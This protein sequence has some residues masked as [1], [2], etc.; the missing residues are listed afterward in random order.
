MRKIMVILGAYYPN[1]SANGICVG[2]I[3]DQLLQDGYSVFC[4]CNSQLGAP[5]KEDI[6][7]LHIRRIKAKAHKKYNE[8]VRRSSNKIQKS[9]YSLLRSLSDIFH[10]VKMTK[11]FPVAS[12]HHAKKIF[13]VANSILIEN[14]IDT[15]I[16][17]NMP[18]DTMYAAYLLK[19]EHPDID[20]IPYS[21]DPIYGGMSNRFLS[22]EVINK[23]NCQFERKMLEACSVFIAQHEHREHFEKCHAQFADKLRFAGV[24][25]L[26]NHNDLNLPP[27]RDKKVL[28][29]AGALS[30][31]TRN[32]AYIFEVFKHIDN[33]RLIMYISNGEEWV[34]SA[35]KGIDNIEIHGKIS[36]DEV[37]N[38]MNEADAFLNIGNTQSMFCPSKIVEYISYGK[39]IVSTYRTDNDTCGDYMSKYPLGVYLDERAVNVRDAAQKIENV[40]ADNTEVLSYNQ[41]KELYADNT[42][43]YVVDLIRSLHGSKKE[44]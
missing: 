31:E 17:I 44:N 18:T 33:V 26:V 15:V 6:D 29:Y 37:L 21:L 19:K 13:K 9:F 35:A 5:D 32:P 42:P 2:C 36:H 20:F 25:L 4:L 27:K 7:N 30:K 12:M 38:K 14:D 39:P 40:I 23:R 11:N 43:A 16:G 28:L 22:E 10:V 8:M 24:P 34:K 41:L 3:V 1:P